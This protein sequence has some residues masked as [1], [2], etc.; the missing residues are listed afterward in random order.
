MADGANVAQTLDEIQEDHLTCGICLER[1]KKPKVLSCMHTFC[2]HCLV[3]LLEKSAGKL[4][5]PNCSAICLLEQEGIRGLKE[6][7]HKTVSRAVVEYQSHLRDL[8]PHLNEKKAVLSNSICRVTDAQERVAGNMKEEI[9]IVKHATKEMV[10]TIRNKKTSV[11]ANIEMTR[12]ESMKQFEAQ[13]DKLSNQREKVIEMCSHIQNVLGCKDNTK[14]L[15]LKQSTLERIETL[16]TLDV[17]VDIQEESLQVKSQADLITAV[18]TLTAPA[19]ISQCTIGGNV[20]KWLLRG[21]SLDIPFS[22]KDCIGNITTGA[23]NVNAVLTKPNGIKEEMQVTDNMDGTFSVTLH[24]NMTGTHKVSVTVGGKQI[25]GSPIT[26]TVLGRGLVKTVGKYGCGILQFNNIQS[27]AINNDDDI[28]VV[29]TNNKRLQI[30]TN[31]GK[32]KGIIPLEFCPLDVAVL[33]DNTYV[34]VGGDKIASIS[35]DR[36][37]IQYFN[38][39]GGN[40]KSATISPVNGHIYA[41]SK[42]WN[43]CVGVYT[44]EG[45]LIKW[46]KLKF[47]GDCIRFNSDNLLY[48]NYPNVNVYQA[49]GT[50]LYNVCKEGK[51]DQELHNPSSLAFDKQNNMYVTSDHKVQ[52]FNQVGTFLERIDN[53]EDGLNQP[54]G[55]VVTADLRIF[56]ADGKNNCIKIFV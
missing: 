46:V 17:E 15:R 8:L 19:C 55:I 25:Q 3:S 47:A 44:P 28:V 6:H 18:L 7:V 50:F 20:A 54:R 40:L 32:F 41:L 39:E 13:M 49:D 14:Q 33:N 23:K 31:E 51:L 37:I 45:K 42:K 9:E 52:K 4:K 22:T 27:M 16:L 36:Q 30:I 24:G 10:S 5:C 1:Y 48:N 11:I 21:C 56:V 53:V 26:T 34:V 2:E 12:G 35:S 29:D 43:S 38:S